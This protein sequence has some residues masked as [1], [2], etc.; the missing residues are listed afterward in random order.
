MSLRKSIVA[1]PAVIA[2]LAVAAPAASAN[3]A[4]GWPSAP[5]A[6]VGFVGP[7]QPGSIGCL[8]L[9]NRIRF[10]VATGYTAYANLL[11]NAFLYTGCGG[12]AI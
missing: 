7:L 12:A 10:A 9:V 4:V 1:L 8:F 6:N 5:T 3:T 11:S 2:A